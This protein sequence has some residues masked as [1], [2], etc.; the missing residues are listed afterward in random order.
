MDKKEYLF[1]TLSRTNRK[2][3]ENYVVNRVYSRLNDLEIQPVTQQYVQRPNLKF[4]LLD[5]YFPQ[6]NLAVECDEEKHK[7]TLEED[8]IRTVDIFK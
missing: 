2:D 7:H 4:A 6:F 1:K 8:Q 3:K 5:L